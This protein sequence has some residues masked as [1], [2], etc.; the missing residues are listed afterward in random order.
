MTLA[1]GPLVAEQVAQGKIER[2]IPGRFSLD[3]TFDTGENAGTPV[4]EDYVDKMPFKFTGDIK[5]VVI[6]LGKSGLTASDENEDRRSS[7]LATS[8]TRSSALRAP[9]RFC[10]RGTCS[11]SL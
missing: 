8:R 6:E 10:A 9:S 11:G 7:R 1:P 3:E 2:T 4:I 5:K